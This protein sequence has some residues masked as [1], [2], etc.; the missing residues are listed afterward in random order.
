MGHTNAV[1]K[2]GFQCQAIGQRKVNTFTHRLT[3]GLL[4]RQTVTAVFLRQGT[5][6]FQQVIVAI[7]KMIY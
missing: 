5:G 3:N 4:G 6:C 1:A 2:A 7:S